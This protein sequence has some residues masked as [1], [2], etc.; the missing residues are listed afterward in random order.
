MLTLMFIIRHAQVEA[1]LYQENHQMLLFVHK[2]ALWALF[3][4]QF[5]SIQ[6]GKV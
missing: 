5:S 2:F 3:P 4:T 1:D 6:G